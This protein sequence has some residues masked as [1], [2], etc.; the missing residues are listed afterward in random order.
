MADAVSDVLD[1]RAPLSKARVIDAAIEFADGQGIDALSMRRLARVLG[2]EA[3]SLY[4]YVRSK[5]EILDGILDR[6]LTQVDLPAGDDWKAAI[7]GA[8][9]SAH[10]VL[11]QHPWAASLTTSS[12]VSPS[13]LR[14]TEFL[15]GSLRRAGF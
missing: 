12:I 1:V 11:N 4:H 15:L 7:R 10:D 5:D 14:L 8:A 6:V 3:M 9:I 13:R 2:V